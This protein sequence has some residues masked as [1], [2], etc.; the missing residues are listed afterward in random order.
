MGRVVSPTPTPLSSGRVVPALVASYDMHGRAV[1]LFYTQPTGQE[2]A[3]I[4]IK[5]YREEYNG[6]VKVKFAELKT[7]LVQDLTSEVDLLW[8]ACWLLRP[9][10]PSW[11]GVM[12]MVHQGSF[13]GQ[14]SVMFMPMIDMNPSDKTCIYSTLHYIC[15]EA[16]RNNTTLVL[17]FDQPLW[18]KAL[19]I[20]SSE[21]DD[22]KLHSIVLRLGPFHLEMSFLACI[23]HLMEE[24]GL[25]EV[26]S[27]VYAPNAVNNML[28]GKSCSACRSRTFSC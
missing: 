15:G 18:W 4:D 9:H 11:S 7:M 24:T 17:T 10:R 8:K 20:I 16:K 27:T 14:S 28:H 2:K 25:H 23:G 3:K 19:S 26:L 1:G 12:Q 6:L 5:Y 21:P 13:P 22:S